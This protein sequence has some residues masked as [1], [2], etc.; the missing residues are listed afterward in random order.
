MQYSI[1][2][3]TSYE[4]NC[5]LVWCEQEKT[6]AVID[7]GGD[8]DRILDTARQRQVAISKLLITHGHFDHCAQAAEL[9]KHLD[10]PIEGPHK[11]DQVILDR[12]PE[13]C[14]KFD[15]PI[16]QA[17]TPDRWL[18]N[19]D[20][21]T[22]GR[23]SLEVIHCPGHTPGHLVFYHRNSQTAFVGDV[24]FRGAV[25]RTDIPGGNHAVLMDSIRHRLLP[26][27]DDVRFIP[28]HG[29]DSTFGMER[30]YNP[31]LRQ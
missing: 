30:Q 1:I 2:P 5:S 4:Q 21:C 8:I 14:E 13:W 12:L 10:I 23:V 9:A 19:G 16:G 7:P 22:I 24:I 6:A 20:L 31:F 18:D 29:P 17:F 27:G 15:F 11:D 25:G 3:V 28:G 26:L